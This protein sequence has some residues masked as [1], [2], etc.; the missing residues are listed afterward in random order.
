E[1]ELNEWLP[2]GG[3]LE[4]EVMMGL[5]AAITADQI[6]Q[7]LIALVPDQQE[8]LLLRFG[9]R[10]DLQTTADIMGK[11]ANAI[12]QLQFRALTALRKRLSGL[13]TDE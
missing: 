1:T 12:K 4:A 7:A 3:D 11:S 10:L 8:V 13:M 2:D 6:R 5:D 9:Q